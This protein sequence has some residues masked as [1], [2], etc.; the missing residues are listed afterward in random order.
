[1]VR[2]ESKRPPN[3]DE[4]VRRLAGNSVAFD[5]EN[6]WNGNVDMP[7]GET[8][9]KSMSVWEFANMSG[10]EREWDASSGYL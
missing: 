2:I 3:R 9:L 1:M 6:H 10:D 8:G 5:P 7:E 4:V